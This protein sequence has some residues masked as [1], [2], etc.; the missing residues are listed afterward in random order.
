M[1]ILKISIVASAI[2]AVFMACNVDACYE[3]T[4]SDPNGVGTPVTDETCAS[5]LSQSDKAAFAAEFA[6]QHDPSMY[7][8]ECADK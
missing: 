8:I 4:A 7:S 3:C 2:G 6:T 1:N 5:E